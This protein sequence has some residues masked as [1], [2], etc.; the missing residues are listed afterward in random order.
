MAIS[1]NTRTQV[2]SGSVGS[3]AYPNTPYYF[4]IYATATR[5]GRNASIYLEYIVHPV[6]SHYNQYGG[7]Y[8]EFYVDGDKKSTAH[9]ASVMNDVTLATYTKSLSAG[10]DGKFA[11]TSVTGKWYRPDNDYEAHSGPPPRDLTI[12]GTVTLPDLPTYTVQF[13]GNGGTGTVSNLTKIDSIDL[14]LPSGGFTKTGYHMSAWNKGS[15][16]GTAYVLGGTYSDNEAA[17]FYAKWAINTYSVRFNANGGTGT[18]SNESFTYGVAKTLTANA[19]TR[20]G[21]RF[22][23]WAISADGE[24]IYTDEQSVI[25]MTTVDNGIVDLYAVW[26]PSGMRVK[27]NGE[28]KDGQVFVKHNGEW[29]AGQVYA[30]DNGTWKEGT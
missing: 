16:S 8:Y 25:N 10:D 17:T 4:Y 1:W 11:S 3:W 21:Y 19:F 29:K 24:V 23:G 7:P 13:D 12:T 18:M 30:K 20:D 15:T 22:I 2:A 26:Q 27:Y 6:D 9:V 28:W 5:S 14:T